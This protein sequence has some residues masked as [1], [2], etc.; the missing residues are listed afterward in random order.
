MQFFS[1]LM[2]KIEGCSA[3]QEKTYFLK[4]CPAVT[5]GSPFRRRTNMF[6]APKRVWASHPIASPTPRRQNR[7]AKR[8]ALRY[9]EHLELRQL[10]SATWTTTELPSLTF[11][12]YNMTSDN[13]GNVFA[14]TFNSGNDIVLEK[15]AGT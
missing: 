11:P 8:S 3:N 12:I 15:H 9:L 13:A 5:A 10:L 7:R 1:S 2:R 14:T 6:N 4:K